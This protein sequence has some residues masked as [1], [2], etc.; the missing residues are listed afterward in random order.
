M[1]MWIIEKKFFLIHAL[2]FFSN[3]GKKKKSQILKKKK[4]NEMKNE[5]NVNGNDDL[6]KDLIC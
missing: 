6:S 1:C 2:V 5:S 3:E 4:I